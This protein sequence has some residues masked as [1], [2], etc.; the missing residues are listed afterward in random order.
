MYTEE[1]V[2]HPALKKYSALLVPHVSV[3]NDLAHPLCRSVRS[4]C[5]IFKGWGGWDE[6]TYLR[7]CMV[8]AAPPP[9]CSQ[10]LFCREGPA[11]RRAGLCSVREYGS[12]SR[13]PLDP[14]PW[15][16]AGQ[17]VGTGK[18]LSASRLPVLAFVEPCKTSFF[19]HNLLYIYCVFLC[20][21]CPSFIHFPFTLV[22]FSR[23]L[24]SNLFLTVLTYFMSSTCP[25]HQ[26]TQLMPTGTL[27]PVAFRFNL[28]ALHGK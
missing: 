14:L 18:L 5:L 24:A 2:E 22:S 3:F 12:L 17:M 28:L 25:P 10:L 27:H 4:D 13:R 23:T 26:C 9:N 6:V 1:I 19:Q 20:S 11:L 21:Y 7:L 15:S 8:S 16:P